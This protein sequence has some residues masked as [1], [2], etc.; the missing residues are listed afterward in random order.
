[1][2]YAF[3]PFS[4]KRLSKLPKK[5]NTPSIIICK[6]N[7]FCIFHPSVQCHAIHKRILCLLL[8]YVATVE[9]WLAILHRNLHK[10]LG[11]LLKALKADLKRWNELEFGSVEKI[12]RG[13]LD[14]LNS[15]DVV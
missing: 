7:A 15:L 14:E 9:L 10:P 12:K 8:R 2:D 13:L 1:M 5:K 11:M 4:Q 3:P 6:Q